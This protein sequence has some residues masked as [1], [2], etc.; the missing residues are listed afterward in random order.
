MVSASIA[1]FQLQYKGLI[2]PG[3]YGIYGPPGSTKSSIACSFPKPLVFYDF[4]RGLHRARGGKLTVTDQGVAAT[5]FD[6]PGLITA[7]YPT[8]PIR[9]LTT[10][11][12]KLDGWRKAWGELVRGFAEDCENPDIKTVV[13]DTATFEWKMCTECVLEELQQTKP[14][15]KQ[16]LQMEYGEPNSRQN[17]MLQAASIYRKNLVLVHHETDEYAPITMG[18]RAV[19]DDDGNPKSAP[20]GKKIP[21]GFRYTIGKCDWVF[22]VKV[23]QRAPINLN[24]GEP[25]PKVATPVAVCQKSALGLDLLGIE[26]EWL[27]Y[28]SLE[29]ALKTLGRV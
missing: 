17:T 5:Y 21:D 1:N 22:Y 16:L 10:R 13:W 24:G 4:D 9:S 19:T 28:G 18:G 7:K 23:E 12:E 29:R 3:L 2:A 20:T 27:T 14:G 15:R 8:I 26:F 6:A 11:Y 25:L